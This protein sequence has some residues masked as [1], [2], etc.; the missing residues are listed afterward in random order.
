[1][2]KKGGR[3]RAT[4]FPPGQ[5]KRIKKNIELHF[6]L[7]GERGEPLLHQEGKLRFSS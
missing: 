5:P 3:R 6:S 7:T 2:G 4:Q 1:M